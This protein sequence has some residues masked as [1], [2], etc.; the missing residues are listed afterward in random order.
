MIFRTEAEINDIVA[1]FQA[2]LPDSDG[3]PIGAVYCRYS[4]VHQDSIADQ[5]RSIL[6]DAERQGIFVPRK[7][8]FYD[9][10]VRGYKQ[11]RNG[12]NNL[13]ECLKAGRVSVVMFFAT[14]R[15]FRKMHRS[16]Q[17]VEEEIVEAGLRAVFVKSGV[18]TQDKERWRML[19]A[20]HSMMDEFVVGMYAENIRSAHE[21]LFAKQ[22]VFG[23][24]SYGYRGE[25]IAG[26]TTRRGRPRKKL[27]IDPVTSMIVNR[28]FT[29]FCA[30][31]ISINEIIR[32]LNDE[33]TVP[34]PPRCTS[35][36]WTRLAVKGLLTNTRYRGL[37]RYGVNET[38]WISSKDSARQKPRREPLREMQIEELRIVPDDLWFEAQNRLHARGCHRGR[39]S[40]DGNPKR[41]PRILNGILWCPVH[42][43]SLHVGGPFGQSMFCPACRRQK[44]N[45]R[46]LFSYLNR[47]L[48]TKLTCEKLAKLIRSDDSL[49]ARIIDACEREV[50]TLQEPDPDRLTRLRSKVEQIS[51]R[52]HFVMDNVGDTEADQR[53]SSARLAE[54]RRERAVIQADQASLESNAQKK[55]EIPT[56]DQ[57]TQMLVDF[58]QILNDATRIE[59]LSLDNYGHA[60][61]I[62]E[63]LTGGRIELSQFGESKA[64]RGWLRGRFI[65]RLLN[66]AVKNL[67]GLP[68]TNLDDG[69]EVTIDYRPPASYDAEAER[70]REFYDR[71]MLNK[72]IARELGCG[73]AQ[74]VKLLDHAFEKRGE[75]RPDGRRRRWT[76][77]PQQAATPLYTQLADP[78]KALWDEG[79]SVLEIARRQ[80]CSDATIWKALVHWHKS[81]GLAIPTARDRHEQLVNRVVGMYDLGMTIKDIAAT[82]RFSTR[83]ITLWMQQWHKDRGL[84]MPDGRT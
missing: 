84:E 79:L 27:T 38:F 23:T 58:S 35:G 68:A 44:G 11:E 57:V 80:D 34:L 17:F 18:D 20:F 67:I 39:R 60:R 41:R 46:A 55:R 83:S 70:A 36:M 71:G 32:R 19:L 21:G 62:I 64:Q 12:L 66:V 9:M 61:G 33:P 30:D 1:D 43:Q 26:Q 74:V 73:T 47:Q 48:A 69:I 13:R 52:I 2:R 51:H 31:R 81:R 7:N 76:V 3:K 65:L 29:W 28:I 63:Q 53:E 15:L 4:T 78:V 42:D 40:N 82:L 59:S 45:Q 77:K 56:E 5:V 50:A 49:V 22:L 10:A 14:N 6:K 72:S 37:W 8:V 25:A 24:I 75:K 54:L 16:L